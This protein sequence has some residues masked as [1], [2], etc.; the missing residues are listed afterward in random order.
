MK[1][2]VTGVELGFGVWRITYA[3]QV[4]ARISRGIMHLGTVFD[5]RLVGV[6]KWILGCSTGTFGTVWLHPLNG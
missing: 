5:S 3:G 1:P 6:L 4:G 2:D